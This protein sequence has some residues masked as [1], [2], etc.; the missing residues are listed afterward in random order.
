MRGMPY[1][2]R[3]STTVNALN[4]RR[5][6]TL[7][8]QS[9][10]ATTGGLTRTVV[11]VGDDRP[12]R[13]V[14]GD[15][16]VYRASALGMC[17]KS[18][19]ALGL[20]HK[21]EPHP[22]WLLKRFQEGVDG[23]P[24]VIDMLSEN[25]V[26][27][28]DYDSSHW[29]M[30]DKG[31]ILVE[32]PVGQR[33]VIRGHAD[34]LATCFKVPVYEHGECE[35]V[36]GDRRLVEIK[37]VSEDYARVLLRKLPFYY[38]VQIVVYSKALGFHPMLALGIKDENG[39]VIN[40]VTQMIEPELTMGAVKARVVEIE[41]WIDKGELPPCDH[42]NWPCQFPWMCDSPGGP[43]TEDW[44]LE[45]KLQESIEIVKARVRSRGEG[46]G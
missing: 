30:W 5:R 9:C 41:K 12:N 33:V 16:V 24:V 3:R 25:W 35:W 19:V 1:Q 46:A 11:P 32:V 36:A 31:Q 26:F 7:V 40:V 2:C 45:A 13:Y 18:L 22:D 39:E 37:C 34:G 23:E 27:E 17:M 43:G 38:I 29:L 44:E 6:S 10:R 4:A 14:E 21:P 8:M 28:H 15:R 42:P 20:G